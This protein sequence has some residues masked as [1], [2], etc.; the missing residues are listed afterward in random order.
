VGKKV[1]G[2]VIGFVFSFSDDLFLH[3]NKNELIIIGQAGASLGCWRFFFFFFLFLLVSRGMMLFLFSLAYSFF[4]FFFLMT[5]RGVTNFKRY[6][7]H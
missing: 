7:F 1:R 6:F 3:F 5:P 4:F 2:V